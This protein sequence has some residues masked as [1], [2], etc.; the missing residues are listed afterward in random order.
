MHLAGVVVVDAIN[1]VIVD[2][3]LFANMGLDG[4]RVLTVDIRP[5]LVQ[6]VRPFR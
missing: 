1:R 6:R 4:P 3:N 5:F 2:R